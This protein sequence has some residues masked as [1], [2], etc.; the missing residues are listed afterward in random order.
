MYNAFVTEEYK[1]KGETKV[2]H[3]KVGVGFDA[4]K[5]GV[6][7]IFPPGVSVSGKVHVRPQKEREAATQEIDD[8]DDFLD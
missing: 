2:R 6:D 7:V 1:S 4:K 3:H 8:G 5:G